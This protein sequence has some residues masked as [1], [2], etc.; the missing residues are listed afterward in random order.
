MT[1]RNIENGPASKRTARKPKDVYVKQ[2]LDGIAEFKLTESQQEAVNVA[3]ENTLTFIEGVAGTGKTSAI[4]WDYCKEYLIDGS[5]SLVVIRSPMEAGSFDKIGMLPGT[6]AEKSLVH[7]ESTRRILNQ[8]LGKNKVDCDMEKRI[9]LLIPNYMIGRTIDNALI[10][11]DE[12][13]V[14][15][16]MILKLILERI[17]INSRCV[18]MGD[19]NQLYTD[20]KEAK[21]RNGLSDALDRFVYDD[22]SG[23]F[24]NVGYFRFDIEDVQRSEIVKTVIRAYR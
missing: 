18:V 17:G 4:L 13:Q 7:F 9:E 2:V 11:V 8:F 23:K 10:L 19:P 5:K 1:K 3:R 16:P 6:L 12:A 15:Q 20:S 24:P 14:L 21:Q 22:G